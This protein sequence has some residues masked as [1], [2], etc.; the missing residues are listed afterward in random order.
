MESGQTLLSQ[1][2][3][4]TSPDTDLTVQNRCQLSTQ[5]LMLFFSILAPA[6]SNSQKKKKHD[7]NFFGL[8]LAK[9][10]FVK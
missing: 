1:V 9:I 10:M 3:N 8:S 5:G 4:L 6:N 2:G 7:I